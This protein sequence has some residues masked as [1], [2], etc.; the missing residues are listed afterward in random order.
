MSY[1]RLAPIAP[2][3]AWPRSGQLDGTSHG[4]LSRGPLTGQL[5][6]WARRDSRRSVVA[7]TAVDGAVL[8]ARA[9]IAAPQWPRG[10]PQQT[11]GATALPMSD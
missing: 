6:H 2:A 9:D 11:A 7:G 5:L 4:S 3:Y 10:G 8:P 1:F